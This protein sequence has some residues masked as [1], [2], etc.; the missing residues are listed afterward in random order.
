MQTAITKIME[1]QSASGANQKQAI[2][3]KYK[4]N[5]NF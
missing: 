1:L 2:L 5:E 3:R 4:E